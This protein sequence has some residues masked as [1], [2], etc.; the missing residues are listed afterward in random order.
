MA[1]LAAKGKSISPIEDTI[2]AN[3]PRIVEGAKMG[4]SRVAIRGVLADNGFHVGSKEGFRLALLRVAASQGLDLAEIFQ[5]RGVEAVAPAPRLRGA[6]VSSHQAA[7]RLGGD[8]V[9]LPIFPEPDLRAVN[10][11]REQ[12]TD[13]AARQQQRVFADP[14]F[15]SDY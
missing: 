12:T 11:H 5:R 9:D 3:W 1:T 14:R 2:R 8:D 4:H 13:D 10:Q 7:P 15:T 6:E